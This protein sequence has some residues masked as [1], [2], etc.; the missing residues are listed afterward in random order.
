MWQQEANRYNINTILLPLGRFD[1]IELVR[2]KEFCDSTLWQ[3]VYLDEVSAVFVR[4][5]APGANDL[6]QRYPVNCANTPLP[7]YLYSAPFAPAFNADANAAAILAALGRNSEA[8]AVIDNALRIFPDSPFAHWLRGSLL[9]AMNRP[10]EAQEEYLAAVSLE[11]SDVTWSALADFYRGHGRTVEAID[12]M[13]RAAALSPR[14]YS[15]QSN[16]GYLYLRANRPQ[17]ALQAFDQAERGVPANVAAADN[18]TFDFMLA[19]GRSVAWNQLGNTARAITFQEKAAQL[20][21]DAPEPWQRLAKLY[22]S[23]G[24]NEDA[25]RAELTAAAAQQK[26]GK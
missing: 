9:A 13:K 4:R 7:L 22:R 24:R 23:Q 19:Q 10:E 8:L 1:G 25:L 21:P 14:P 20:Q 11:S 12:A 18:G 16:L 26:Q 2:L 3:P 15:L 17:D 6:L 5:D